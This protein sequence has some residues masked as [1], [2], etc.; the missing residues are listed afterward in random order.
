MKRDSRYR[1]WLGLACVV[2]MPL[3]VGG[4]AFADSEDQGNDATG[5]DEIIVRATRLDKRINE[6]PAA[7]S[8]VTRDD[9]Q[10][11]RQQLA[12]DESLAAIPGVFIQ[13]RYNFSRDLRIAIRGFGARSGFGIRGVKILVDGIPESLPDGQGQSDAIDLGSTAQIEVI[14]GPSSSLYGNASGG[15]INITSERGP[16]IPF[17]ETRLTVGEF[18]YSQVQL[19]TGGDT[20]R[21]NYLVN[22]SKM[23]FDGYRAHS[24]AENTLLNARFVY[25]INDESEL[26]LVL[27]ATDQPV[28]ND[29]GGIDLAQAEADPTSARQRNVDFDTGEVERRWR[30]MPHQRPGEWRHRRPSPERLATPG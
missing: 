10:R 1:V 27:N 17:A 16:A 30:S 4:L 2:A 19:K 7:I 5:L 23:D 13:S 8:V 12:L 21:L 22:F 29:P 20:G 6:V 9:I 18:D 28:A 24:Q 15:V 11:G 25:T 26:G 14:R 3:A